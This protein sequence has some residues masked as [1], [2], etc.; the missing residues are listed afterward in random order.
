MKVS[1]CCGACSLFGED[2]PIC[3]DC[4]EHCELEEENEEELK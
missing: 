1:N 3:S 4:K 2:D